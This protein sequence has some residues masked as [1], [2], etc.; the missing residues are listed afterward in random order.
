[1]RQLLHWR[2]NPSFVDLLRQNK[3]TESFFLQVQHFL[4]LYV[5]LVITYNISSLTAI[6]Q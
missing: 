6:S 3:L 1:M 2:D 4:S 5:M